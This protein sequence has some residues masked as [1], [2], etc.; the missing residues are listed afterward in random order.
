MSFLLSTPQTGVDSIFVTYGMLGPVFAI[1]RPVVAFITGIVGGAVM[2]GMETDQERK[3]VERQTDASGDSCCSAG[4][5]RSKV[6]RALHYG[7]VSAP[8]DIAKPMLVGL[9][10]AGVLSALVPHDFFAGR[11]GSGFPAMIVMML[12]GIPLYVCATASVPIA[13]ALITAGVSP[14]AALVFLITGPASNTATIATV[15][16]VLGK[17]A[18]AVYLGTIAV[19][20]LAAG[21]TLDLLFNVS[22][23]NAAELA[24][25]TSTSVFGNISAVVLIGVIAYAILKPLGRRPQAETAGEVLVITGMSCAHCVASI[26]RALGECRGVGS[27][28][29]DLKSGK[30]TITGN[31]YRRQDLV[32][33]VKSLGFGIA[34]LK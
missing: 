34:D 26:K 2:N 15:W 18:T 21:Y 19:T 31:G 17:K 30:A 29:V 23:V 22:G 1:Y 12:I 11:F 25:C 13:A 7:F 32:D 8:A 10:V 28:D 16:K 24:H 3:P 5:G 33:A 14:G 20:S 9:L 27:V 4:A 6:M